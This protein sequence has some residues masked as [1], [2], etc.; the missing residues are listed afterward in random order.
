MS[1]FSA[2]LLSNTTY[3][4]G[5]AV[6]KVIYVPYA[7]PVYNYLMSKSCQISTEYDLGIWN[8]TTGE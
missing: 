4:L 8:E 3:Y 7:Y 6:S 2:R 1:K 5:V